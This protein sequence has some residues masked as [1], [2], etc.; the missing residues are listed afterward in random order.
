MQSKTF[1]KSDFEHYY[2][3]QGVNLA[4][5]TF[6]D[7]KKGI[8]YLLMCFEMELKK[9][10]IRDDT[11]EQ[12]AVAYSNAF[13]FEA[14]NLYFYLALNYVNKPSYLVHIA[15]NYLLTNKIEQGAKLLKEVLKNPNVTSYTLDFAKNTFDKLKTF[16]DEFY[17]IY[18]EDNEEHKPNL[19][20]SVDM[21]RNY[22][23]MGD[24]DSAIETYKSLNS[25]GRDGV[26][27][28]LTLAYFFSGD[29]EKAEKLIEDYGRDCPTDLSNLLLIYN[30]KNDKKKYEEVKRKLLELKV[31]NEKERF[32][33]GLAFAQTGEP[34]LA[35][36][37]MENFVSES[38]EEI[39]VNFYFAL[40]CINAK[41]YDKAKEQLI[42][43]RDYDFFNRYMY[44]YYL[45]LCDEE[46]NERVEYVFNIPMKE[47]IRLKGKL[48]ELLLLDS[49]KLEIYF[50]ENFNMFLYVAKLQEVENAQL[51]LYKLAKIDS[52]YASLLFNF[53]FVTDFLPIEVKK[54]LVLLRSDVGKRN[55][56]GITINNEPL[57]SLDGKKV[58]TFENNFDD[59]MEN[60]V[61]QFTKNNSFH[62]TEEKN[63]D[64]KVQK[65]KIR[66][67][68]NKKIE[69]ANSVGFVKDDEY[70]RFRLPNMEKLFKA[71]AIVHDATLF[72]FG[73]IIDRVIAGDYDIAQIV[74]PLAKIVVG[75]GVE[76]LEVATYIAWK[77]FNDKRRSLGKIIKYF[78]VDAKSFYALLD[79]FGLELE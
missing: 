74:E 24:F 20:E 41:L 44:D 66:E 68:N 76:K 61:V 28:E 43:L 51:L 35:V 31:E 13:N 19:E 55:F 5:I 69:I 1:D 40:A 56:K 17:K 9:G 39:E 6:S 3:T 53:I 11:L 12:I 59:L 77:F 4:N 23:T 10:V 52:A 14:S 18:E 25:L 22:M 47:F 2:F 57:M 65:N 79:R 60:K 8:K 26:R 42:S 70:Y 78:N 50:H 37:F 62:N 54:N 73:Y 27:S 34:K 67:L 46:R 64:K 58:A 21:A 15:R 75:E 38:F 30:A 63:G 16:P 32:N 45:K 7:V 36:S 49:K 48:S 71:N 29:L 33:I 72:A